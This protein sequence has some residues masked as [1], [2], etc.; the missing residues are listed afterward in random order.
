LKALAAL[1]VWEI[2]FAARRHDAFMDLHY[3]AFLSA[4]W[5][6][7]AR[8]SIFFQETHQPRLTQRILGTRTFLGSL[9][10]WRLQSLL[11]HESSVNLGYD[12]DSMMLPEISNAD[13]KLGSFR[14]DVSEDCERMAALLG[15]LH[16]ESF[17]NE[18][19]QSSN[20]IR[21]KEFF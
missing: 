3:E 13:R 2:Q 12:L 5:T 7:K 6:V 8:H 10:T 21:S 17:L 19:P 20:L 15:T 11:A 16:S 4:T 14:V 1:V 18:S 9:F